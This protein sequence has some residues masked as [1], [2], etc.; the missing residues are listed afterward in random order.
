MNLY[1]NYYKVKL[2]T[3]IFDEVKKFLEAK[4]FSSYE[5]DMENQIKTNPLISFYEYENCYFVFH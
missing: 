1:R 2:I 3:N 4:H 5:I